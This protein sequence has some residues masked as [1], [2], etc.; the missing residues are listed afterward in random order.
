M[1]PFSIQLTE[2]S[3]K[4][5][6]YLDMLLFDHGIMTRCESHS[7]SVPVTVCLCTLWARKPHLLVQ[8]CGS[9]TGVGREHL[10]ITYQDI[11]WCA[12]VKHFN[13]FWRVLPEITR[14]QL[15]SVAFP[16]VPHFKYWTLTA[17]E[18]TVQYTL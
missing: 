11:V 6:F 4:F 15:D 17:V 14:S 7:S 18:S 12:I 13:P 3:E 1:V 8:D 2:F 9:W 5:N 10:C 16:S